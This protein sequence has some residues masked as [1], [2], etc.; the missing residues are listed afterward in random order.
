MMAGLA[1]GTRT[2]KMSLSGLPYAPH[3]LAAVAF[4][5]LPSL[6]QVRALLLQRVARLPFR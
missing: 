1:L 3:G 4:D 2:P 5:C 6:T